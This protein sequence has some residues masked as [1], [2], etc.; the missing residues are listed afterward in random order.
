MQAARASNIAK[1]YSLG[2]LF[3]ASKVGGESAA[4]GQTAGGCAGRA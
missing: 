2:L 3:V 1:S 4:R